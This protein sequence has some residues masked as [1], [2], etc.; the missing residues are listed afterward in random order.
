MNYK[1]GSIFP[2]FVKKNI[3]YI[4]V[5]RVDL[6][7]QFFRCCEG[8]VFDELPVRTTSSAPAFVGEHK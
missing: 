8:L 2:D 7:V 3:I 6:N 4:C 1:L 5:D